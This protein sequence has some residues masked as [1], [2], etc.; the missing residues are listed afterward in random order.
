MK[1]MLRKPAII[2]LNFYGFEL[3]TVLGFLLQKLEFY[4]ILYTI[5]NLIVTFFEDC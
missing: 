5:L 2:I 4:S 1:E 3:K